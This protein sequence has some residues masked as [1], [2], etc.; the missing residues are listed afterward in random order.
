MGMSC[1][2]RLVQWGARNSAEIL[3]ATG[4]NRKWT[5]ENLAVGQAIRGFALFMSRRVAKLAAPPFLRR[6][7]LLPKWSRLELDDHH[8]RT[9]LARLL[10]GT[11]SRT[12]STEPRIEQEAIQNR[13]GEF[14]RHNYGREMFWEIR[15]LLES[16][17][18]S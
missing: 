4:E 9:I 15:R 17:P 11:V 7:P 14:A 3:L 12:Y 6:H 10:V 13:M 2:T 1:V 8:S 16:H 5:K 18:A